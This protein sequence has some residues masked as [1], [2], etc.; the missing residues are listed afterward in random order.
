MNISKKLFLILSLTIFLLLNIYSCAGSKKS[1][2]DKPSEEEV[3]Q[4]NMDDIE[5]LLGIESTQKD[6]NK[7]PAKKSND[8]KL[9]LLETSDVPPQKQAKAALPPA[10]D[11]KIKDL[12][13]TIREKDQTIANLQRELNVKDDQIQQLSTAKSSAPA[14]TYSA[15]AI[16][17]VSPEE[18]E[19][20]YNEARSAFESRNYEQAI[21]LFESLLASSTNNSLADNAQYWIGECQYALKQ[22]D[23]AILS[24][25]KVFTFTNSNKKDDAQFK[26]GMCYLRKGDKQK[27]QEQFERLRTDYPNSEYIDRID[28][29]LAKY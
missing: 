14:P 18:Y 7:K 24:F 16:G 3:Q 28:K 2:G 27:A 6:A 10:D 21:L 8:E 11:K 17:T 12:E 26:L 4:Q 1:G 13:K 5:A 20:R 19:S 22:Y 29:V 15:G 25:E 23:A 9:G